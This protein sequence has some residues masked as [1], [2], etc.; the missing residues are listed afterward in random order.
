MPISVCTFGRDPNRGL[1]RKASP[2]DGPA[3]R[4]LPAC[5]ARNSDV[6][7]G[8]FRPLC[9]LAKSFHSNFLE[10]YFFRSYSY[11]NPDVTAGRRRHGGSP[12]LHASGYR[13]RT[14]RSTDSSGAGEIIAW[15]PRLRACKGPLMRGEGEWHQ[16][17]EL[18]ID[19]TR[20]ETYFSRALKRQLSGASAGVAC[21]VWSLASAGV[22]G[23]VET[24]KLIN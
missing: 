5:C 23:T 2:R 13:V 22:R 8:L 24:T 9:C 14:L 3:W 10:R 1:R 17:A 7:W 4:C 21:L 19:A 18:H 20:F 12:T 11:Y 16:Q 15:G 6:R